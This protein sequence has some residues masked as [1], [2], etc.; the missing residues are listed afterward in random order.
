MRMFLGG[1]IPA[2]CPV[3]IATNVI[4]TVLDK[5]YQPPT[6]SPGWGHAFT[7]MSLDHF[8]AMCREVKE[9]LQ[10]ESSCPDV[11]APAKVFGDIHGQ[12]VD[13]LLLFQLYG[14]P[15]HRTGDIHLINYIFL[16]D[17]V[18][19]GPHS[20]EVVAMLF[21]LKIVYPTRVTLIRGNHEDRKINI[22][23][24]GLLRECTRRCGASEGPEIWEQINLA[25][26]FLPLG[27]RVEKRI[28]CVH[29]GIGKHVASVE[30]IQAI[31]R[32]LFAPC[33]I[34]L[35]NDLLWSD[36]SKNDHECGVHR[37]DGRAT[38]YVYGPDRVREFCMLNG[39][40]LI[41]RAHQR[42]NGE[43]ELQDVCVDDECRIQRMNGDDEIK[44]VGS[45]EGCHIQRTN[46][47]DAIKDVAVDDECRIQRINGEDEVKDVG[48]DD[49]CRIQ[50]TNG[51]DAIKDVGADEACRIQRT[52]GE[53]ELKD[54]VAD[55]ACRI[56][57]IN[58]EDELKDVGA[59][60]ACRTLI[61]SEDELKDVGV[62]A[63]CR[64]QRI[65]GEDELQDVGADDA[66][67]IQRTNG[68]DE[69]Q[70]VGAD[71]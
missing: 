26:D 25:F 2:S 8:A 71:D 34:D 48:T 59:D 44:D 39:L 63:A 23:S 61:N 12:L 62:D 52:N 70:D 21:A 16:G 69:L 19:R 17:F 37:N 55:E 27:C 56:Q 46:G 3:H 43:D 30:Q 57:R 36:P 66:C 60:E 58:G 67:R 35:V 15:Q 5:N 4:N 33:D 20:M 31:Q 18:D 65:N 53:D 24:Y 1:G 29:G 10:A 6:G 41:I 49:A 11:A 68:E 38:S 51:E 32:P 28:L 40:D 54:V 22:N 64:I 9:L 42:I 7:L 14:L 45:D 13:L 47:E 50:R